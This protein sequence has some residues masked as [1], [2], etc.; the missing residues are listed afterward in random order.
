M[1]FRGVAIT[2]IWSV[3]LLLPFLHRPL[4]V[5][6]ADMEKLKDTAT[7]EE[8]I[9][10]VN[11]ITH[12]EPVVVPE[13]PLPSLNANLFTNVGK[14]VIGQRVVFYLQNVPG[15]TLVEWSTGETLEKIEV[16][17]DGKMPTATLTR[18]QETLVL[19][20]IG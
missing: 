1:I 7:I 10:R 18:G 6:D 17:W 9:T 11:E 20:K 2:E 12:P 14:P 16:V 3:G 8:V 5:A 19:D 13:P 15:G 4:A